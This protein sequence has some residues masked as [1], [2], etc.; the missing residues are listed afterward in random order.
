MEDL[1]E[2]DKKTILRLFTIYREWK[3]HL[4]EY[5]EEDLMRMQYDLTR[6]VIAAET[7]DLD[8]KVEVLREA[9][10]EVREKVGLSPVADDDGEDDEEDEEEPSDEGSE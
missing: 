10:N 2:Q 1:S 9:L 8:E 5:T 4:H 7:I 6:E 3:M